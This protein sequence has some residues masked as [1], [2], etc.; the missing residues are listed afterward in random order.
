MKKSLKRT[1]SLLLSAAMLLGT[2]PSAFAA[3][4]AAFE[5]EPYVLAPAADGMTI[6][7]EADQAVDATISLD[8]G[9]A[10]AV[11]ADVDAPEF[12]GEQMHFYSYRLEN[13]KPDTEYDYTVALAGG[14]SFSASF[15]TLSEDPDEAR[16]IFITDTHAFAA[17]EAL[18][19]FIQDYDPDF[20]I[21]TGD[22]LE[23]TGEYKNQFT[24]WLANSDFIHSV[25][26]IYVPGNHD[27]GD[28]YTEYFGKAQAEAYKA[29]DESGANY[30]FDYAPHLSG[31]SN[32]CFHLTS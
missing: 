23:G 13:L 10:V 31:A 9:A 11:K 20:I 32:L 16:V 28:Y 8:G 12:Q 14:E 19:A 27:Y 7:W 2:M 18:D 26:I 21:H 24:N 15:E 1:L 5:I 4:E 25:P 29:E 3:D 22:I 17:G 30:S 6:A